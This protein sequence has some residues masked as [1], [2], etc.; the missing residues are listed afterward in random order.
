MLCF[1]LLHRAEMK[2]SLRFG[3]YRLKIKF[4]PH[5]ATSMARNE[6]KGSYRLSRRGSS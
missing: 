4:A 2:S 3:N 6:D 5:F 1:R